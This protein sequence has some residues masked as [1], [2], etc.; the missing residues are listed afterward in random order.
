MAYDLEAKIQEL[1]DAVERPAEE[2]KAEIEAILARGINPRGAVA[3]WKSE[4]ALE[5]GVGTNEYFGQLIHVEKAVVAETRRG[6]QEVATAYFLTET[7]DG[8]QILPAPM[9]AERKD[10][11][12]KQFDPTKVY[13]FKAGLNRSGALVRI[14]G[15]EEVDHPLPNIHDLSATPINEIANYI[16]QNVLIRGAIGRKI[17]SPRTF[18][19]VGFEVSDWDSPPIT[20]FVGG[21]FTRFT[22]E[23]LLE[24]G[25]LEQGDEVTVY[26]FVNRSGTN[27]T[28]NARIMAKVP[29]EEQATLK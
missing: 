16:G 15:I 27:I 24:L 23:Q 2:V 6:R 29:I 19:L 22:Q 20:V 11:F 25:K 14:R 1:A 5:L 12:L 3:I 17:L 13:K 10:E 28:V 9:W 7:P 26:G 18:E 4:H 21:R 8:Y